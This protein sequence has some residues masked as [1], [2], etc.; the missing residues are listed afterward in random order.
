MIIVNFKKKTKGITLIALVITIIVLLILV[1]VSIATLTGENGL[2]NRADN[3]KKV[4]TEAEE[5]ERV[6]LVSANLKME[7]FENPDIDE[8]RFQKIVDGQFGTGNAKGTIEDYLYTITVEQ[9]KNVYQINENGEILVIGNTKK[10]EKPGE[11]EGTGTEEDPYTINSIE[12]LVAF[13]HNVN[14][15]VNLYEG[16]VVVLGRSLYFNGAFNSYADENAKYEIK[17][18]TDK[19]GNEHDIAYAPKSDATTSIKELVTTGQGFKPIGLQLG[20]EEA[21]FK[22]TFDG[23]G[24]FIANLYINT[25]NFAGLFGM[26][27][28]QGVIK[29]V[30]IESGNITCA[31]T[32]A[33]G[34]LAYI[35]Q[36]LHDQVII[37]NCY[38]KADIVSNSQFDMMGG[39]VGFGS[40]N[41][42]VKNCYNTA[43][44]NAYNPAGI[45]G[46]I[47]KEILDCYNT[48][49]ITAKGYAGGIIYSYTSNIFIKNCYNT[50]KIT[51]NS[52]G[53][54]VGLANENAV[55]QNCYNT[56]EL[57]GKDHVGGICAQNAKEIIDCYNIGKLT[58]DFHAGGIIGTG[59]NNTFINN[60]YNTAEIEGKDK[61][62]GIC[63]YASDKIINCYN[64][65]NITA[66]SMAGGVS[67]LSTKQVLNCYN[68]GN[69][70]NASQLG[71]ISANQ[72]E[73]IKNVFNSGTILGNQSFIQA[74]GIIGTV[75]N[76]ISEAYNIGDV[77]GDLVG[78][79][80]S[81]AKALENVYNTAKIIGKSSTGGIC[82]QA[83]TITNAYNIGDVK[84]DYPN[85][86]SEICYNA[87][88]NNAYY[89]IKSTNAGISTAEGKTEEEMKELMKMEIFVDLLNSKVAENNANSDNIKWNRWKVVNGRPVFE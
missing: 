72:V 29:N 77:S 30:G 47:A 31:G 45:V 40:D 57:L 87:T 82:G 23:K 70:S 86:T 21:T 41:L 19:E 10:D 73:T 20:N 79:I 83:T 26:R 13:S 62:G 36:Y 39:I 50:G 52:V 66:N 64:L 14:I 53:G 74:G 15:G 88:L 44:I 75:G 24:K 51:A 58:S 28:V 34:I 54:I 32:F 69:I 65:G 85:L 8:N 84:G 67:T 81:S 89:Q 61:A 63:A 42:T 59:G 43:S 46:Y 2:I 25:D 55:I 3:A 71:G 17:K 22:G 48:G 68:F 6:V 60:C 56:A 37:E 35:N 33:G 78:G 9:S 12:D 4:T 38:N 27:N 1:G 76:V 49:E 18:C 16:Q 5:K 80:S 11:L 7:R